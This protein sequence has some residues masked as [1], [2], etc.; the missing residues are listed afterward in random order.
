VEA[1][2]DRLVT[3]AESQ[4]AALHQEFKTLRDD[5]KSTYNDATKGKAATSGATN[6]R[7]AAREALAIQLTRNVLTL[8]LEF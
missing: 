1:I 7:I 4:D 8:S 2:L 6:F 5:W 3:V